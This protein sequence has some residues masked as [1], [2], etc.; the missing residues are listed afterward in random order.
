MIEDA[1]IDAFVRWL[2]SNGG[3]VDTTAMGITE[4]PD[5]GRGAIALCDIPVCAFI[6]PGS[7]ELLMVTLYRH[8]NYSSFGL[9]AHYRKDAPCSHSRAQSRFQ[10]ERLPFLLSLVLMRGVHTDCTRVGLG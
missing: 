1:N 3:Y 7:K 9:Y 6:D 8:L 2:Q 4:Y 5:S 10:H